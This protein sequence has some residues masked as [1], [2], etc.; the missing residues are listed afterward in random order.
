MTVLSQGLRFK[1]KEGLFE[2]ILYSEL[3]LFMI[4]KGRQKLFRISEELNQC[5]AQSAVCL[6]LQI[7]V[8]F[9][10]DKCT[11]KESTLLDRVLKRDWNIS[12]EAFCLLQLRTHRKQFIMLFLI[13]ET[14][15]FFSVYLF[16]FSW[17]VNKILFTTL[18]TLAIFGKIEIS[19]TSKTVFYI[20][21]HQLWL[22]LRCQ[23]KKK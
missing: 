16:F 23:L 5:L 20:P 13:W 17:N 8:I 22:H 15:F 11:L 14:K 2:S 6:P 18:L 7:F 4:L 9:F 21:Q 1:T 10:Q 12:K 19:I 3:N